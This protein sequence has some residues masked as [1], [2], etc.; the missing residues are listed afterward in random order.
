[1][2]VGN[3]HLR[4]EISTSYTVGPVIKPTSWMTLSFEYYYIKKDHYITTG[5]LNP[6]QYFNSWIENGGSNSGEPSGI[7]V[8]PG[9]KDPN[10]P[11]ALAAPGYV[12][13]EYINAKSM[14]TDGFD[15]SIDAHARLPGFLHNIMWYSKLG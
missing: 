4:P 6:N 8:V 13:G 5:I 10:Y 7:T 12:E 2:S 9:P 3:P 15:M 14:M 11:N 1:M